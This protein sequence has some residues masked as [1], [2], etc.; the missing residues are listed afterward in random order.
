[1][2]EAPQVDQ[3]IFLIIYFI[4]ITCFA[5]DLVV[6]V[7]TVVVMVSAK[8]VVKEERQVTIFILINFLVKC[9]H[10]KMV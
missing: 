3:G 4:I 7:V 8:V 6:M 1:M 2:G 10:V 5:Y 9:L